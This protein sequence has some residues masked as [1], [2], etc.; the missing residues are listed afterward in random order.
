MQKV[1]ERALNLLAFLLTASR[2]VTA[3][4]IRS[5][6]AGYGQEGDDAFRRMFERDKELLRRLG[7]PLELRPTDAWEVEFGYVVPE[8][9]YALPDPGL[10][11]E[12]RTALLLAAQAV[13]FGGQPAGADAI[14]KL[15]GAPLADG[16]EPLA[17]ELGGGEELAE[18]YAAVSEH[19][20]L[21][22]TY[23]GR[24][25]ALHPYGLV[26]RRGHWYVVGPELVNGEPG[27]VVKV[28][29][30]DRAVDLRAAGESEAFAP[31]RGFDPAEEIPELPWEAGDGTVRATVRFDAEVAWWAERQL[32]ERTDLRP[33][34]DGGIEAEIP[35]A[36]VGVLLGWLVAF[37]DRAELVGP[38]ELRA[39]YVDLVRGAVR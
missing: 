6:V 32:G 11:D 25:R 2:P 18:A 12:E 29:R 33:L 21:R 15:G 16:G 24:D 28:F 26:H 13:R 27:D 30:L 1:V 3:D 31:P 17:A 10:T 36:R 37:E 8:I 38:P 19:R 39:R 20:V 4:E 22:F 14:L 9:A 34:P 7:V 23:R 35:V 5:T